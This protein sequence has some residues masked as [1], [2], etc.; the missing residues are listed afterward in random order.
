MLKRLHEVDK[1]YTIFRDRGKGSHRMVALG[2]KH[3][4]FPCH[5]DGA[6]IGRHYLRDI[7]KF[8]DLPDDIFD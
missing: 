1:E 2:N 3:Y 4:P 8:F 6:E 5:N 7:I